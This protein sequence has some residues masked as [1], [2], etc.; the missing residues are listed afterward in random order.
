MAPSI[1]W[2]RRLDGPH[3]PLLLPEIDPRPSSPWPIA[4]PT[5]LSRFLG[6]SY[7]ADHRTECTKPTWDTVVR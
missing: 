2:I 6:F 5:E 7:K 1:H 3:S 4:I